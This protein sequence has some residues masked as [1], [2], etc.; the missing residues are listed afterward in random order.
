MDNMRRNRHA[1]SADNK[2]NLNRPRTEKSR[3]NR[4]PIT[5]F[6][7]GMNRA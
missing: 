2:G 4:R 3:R 5:A 6:A 1:Q 7:E